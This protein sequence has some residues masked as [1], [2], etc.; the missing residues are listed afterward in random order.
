MNFGIIWAWRIQYQHK[1]KVYSFCAS[2]SLLI[3][4]FFHFCLYLFTYLFYLFVELKHNLPCTCFMH[5]FIM[6]LSFFYFV[7]YKIFLFSFETSFSISGLTGFFFNWV[8]HLGAV[9]KTNTFLCVPY[10]VVCSWTNTSLSVSHVHMENAVVWVLGI[11]VHS[12]H[13]LLH[14]FEFLHPPADRY[15]GFSLQGH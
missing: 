8:R 5:V 13:A 2:L 15:I 6:Q 1:P 14:P 12:Y 9:S 11:Y 3:L 4:L 7:I 10:T